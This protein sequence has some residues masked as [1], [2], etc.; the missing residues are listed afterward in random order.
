MKR[1]IALAAFGLSFLCGLLLQRALMAKHE[2]AEEQGT[3]N[4]VWLEPSKIAALPQSSPGRLTTQKLPQTDAE[5]SSALA[6]GDTESGAD[7]N[8]AERGLEQPTDT[9]FTARLEELLASTERGAEEARGAELQRWVK[10]AP[11]QAAGWAGQVAA[12]GI[13]KEAIG[14]V[15]TAWAEAD[16]AGALAWVRT[17]PE[18][19]GRTTALLQLGYEAAR[20]QPATALATAAELPSGEERDR[21]LAHAIS[22]SAARDGTA[23][24]AWTAEVSDPLLRQRLI[25]EAVIA[26]A[27]R[28]GAAAAQAAAQQLQPGREQ[29][30]AAVAIVQR[31]AQVSPGDAALWVQSFPATPTR[32]AA[33]ENLM[34][35]WALED[36]AGAQSWILALPAGPFR[37]EAWS[38]YQDIAGRPWFN[39]SLP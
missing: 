11:R 25:S 5:T 22:Q 18:S 28:D 32:H 38:V 35:C 10:V 19:S 31:W 7:L 33:L 16:L 29:D 34:A 39:A 24:L 1:L 3:D 6:G 26:M 13:W 21:L 36:S 4:L 15:A 23:A 12:G 37:D 30:R 20:E 2:S 27:A 8:V 17:L 14:V 9:I